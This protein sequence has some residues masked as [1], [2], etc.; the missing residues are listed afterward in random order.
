MVLHAVY[1]A[2]DLRDNIQAER[3]SGAAPTFSVVQGQ[4]SRNNAFRN[5]LDYRFRQF[6]TGRLSDWILN[7]SRLAQ[8]INQLKNLGNARAGEEC[9][10]TGCTFFPLGPDGTKLYGTARICPVELRSI[11]TEGEKGAPVLSHSSPALALPKFLSW[12]MS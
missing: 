5:S 11:R 10:S 7:W 3:G 9:D 12:L 4:L 1:F 2:S 8:L 6:W